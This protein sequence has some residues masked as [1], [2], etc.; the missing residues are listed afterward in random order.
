MD[1]STAERRMLDAE[2][3]LAQE[4]E[5]VKALCAEKKSNGIIY[6]WI[7]GLML[8]ALMYVCGYLTSTN[9]YT[10]RVVT[11]ELQRQQNT[12][13]ITDLEK[14]TTS[15]NTSLASIEVQLAQLTYTLKTRIIR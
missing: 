12:E 2:E 14:T 15:I 3:Q 4:R 10:T 6:Q 7:I 11:L 13:R 8:A 1:E 5:K 9:Q